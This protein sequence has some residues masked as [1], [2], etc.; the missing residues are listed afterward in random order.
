MEL[1]KRNSSLLRDFVQDNRMW[2]PNT[3]ECLKNYCNV[4]V[5]NF[6]YKCRIHCNVTVDNFNSK[7]RIY[8]ETLRQELAASDEVE[9]AGAAGNIGGNLT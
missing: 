3:V 5:G 7:C 1:F 4:T 8:K 9:M 2:I 6:N